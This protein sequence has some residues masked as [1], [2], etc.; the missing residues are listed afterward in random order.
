MKKILIL[1]LF[2]IFA[3]AGSTWFIGNETESL[4]KTYLKN[5]KNAGADMGLET[6]YYIKDY[7]KSFLKSTATTVVHLNT[8]DPVI[9]ELLGDVQFNNTISHG[10]VLFA[11]GTL[12]FGTAHIYSEL[13]VSSL[14]PETQDIMKRLFA[15][16]SPLSGNITFGINDSSDY[17]LS[18]PA[19]ELKEGE[20]RFSLKDGLYVAGAINKATL[21][22]T[23][24]GT[25]GAVHII[26]DG[27][28][29]DVSASTIDVDM[30]GMVAGQMI[31]TSHFAT[32]SVK[33][34]GNEVPPV[35]F[36]LDFSS[37]TRRASDNEALDGDIK[38]L[39]SNIEAPVDI[40]EIKLSTSFKAFQI[41]G[42]E[43]L[44]AVQKDVQQLQ[45]SALS[46][47]NGAEQ[48]ELMSKLQNL[49]N[50]MI[51]AVQNTLKKD[52]TELQVTAD[53]A[54]QQG[55]SLLDIEARY[56][57]NSTDIN[58][59]ELAMGGLA[60]LQK[61][62]NGKIDFT[63][64]KAMLTSTPAAFF[65]PSLVEKG[66]IAENADNY[67]LNAV[68]KTDG[69]DLNG[70]S[71]SV[72]DFISLMEALGLGGG[73]DELPAGVELPEGAGVP[74]EGIP[75]ELLEELSKQSAEDLKAQGVP[76]EIIE[77]IKP[78]KGEA[79]VTE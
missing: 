62:V 49:P 3:W 33:I 11:N 2:L 21:M 52:K 67:S 77:K 68:F 57:G 43:Q 44:A 50:I 74:M 41:K 54:S 63:A 17:D 55:G 19:I 6:H 65:I 70:K 35:S 60:A 7:K 32:P 28:N 39:A 27:L 76:N 47:M 9:D 56:I 73:D 5:T 18:I 14:K 79:A 26:D 4:F 8:G 46:G 1:I 48:E 45:S 37:D 69:I 40:S 31:G 25:I 10:P 30:Q 34:T 53:I 23:A 58:L 20:S 22:G 78:M 29:I 61:L 36:G 38:L 42:L 59:E 16:K 51:A 75:A 64:P 72:D 12:G 13:D 71:I 66:V 24:K 15:D